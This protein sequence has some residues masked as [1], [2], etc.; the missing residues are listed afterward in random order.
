MSRFLNGTDG[1]RCRVKYGNTL[2]PKKKKKSGTILNFFNGV[3]RG[4]RRVKY[5]KN[6]EKKKIWHDKKK[7]RKIRDFVTARIVIDAA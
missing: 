7:V 1:D 2:P 3:D 6:T 5:E 4:R